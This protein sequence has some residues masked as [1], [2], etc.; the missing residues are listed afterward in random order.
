MAV[1]DRCEAA[2]QTFDRVTVT[3]HAE[4]LRHH[5]PYGRGIRRGRRRRGGARLQRTAARLADASS[6]PFGADDGFHQRVAGEAIGAVQSGAGDLTAGPES[7]DG[8]A[9][10]EIYG[11]AAHM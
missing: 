11:N 10:F 8:A 6:D 5:R 1:C 2:N 3:Q 9:T 4:A 7:I